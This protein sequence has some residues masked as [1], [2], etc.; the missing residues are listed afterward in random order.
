[1]LIVHESRLPLEKLRKISIDVKGAVL[2]PH[3]SAIEL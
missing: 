1:M 3:H 2:D